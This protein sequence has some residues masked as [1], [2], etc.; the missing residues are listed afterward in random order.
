ELES[1]LLKSSKEIKEIKLFLTDLYLQ[2]KE[3]INRSHAAAEIP[4]MSNSAVIEF[5]ERRNYLYEILHFLSEQ[6]EM[7][8]N[9]IGNPSKDT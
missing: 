9:A 2:T 3:A 1:G 8:M 5:I 7:I 6:F 4:F